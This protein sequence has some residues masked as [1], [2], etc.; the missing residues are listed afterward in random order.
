MSSGLTYVTIYDYDTGAPP[1]TAGAMQVFTSYD[2]AIDFA[3]YSAKFVALVLTSSSGTAYLI[4]T[5]G[6]N[7]NGYVLANATSPVFVPFD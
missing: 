6:P 4:T 7:Q 1:N 2:E 3:L 5:F